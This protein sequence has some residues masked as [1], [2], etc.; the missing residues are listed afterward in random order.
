MVFVYQKLRPIPFIGICIAPLISSTLTTP[1][2][3]PLQ[4]STQ[5]IDTRTSTKWSN[6]DRNDSLPLP[7]SPQSSYFWSAT[8]WGPCN[9][10]CGG[11][12]QVQLTYIS[13]YY[14]L[15]NDV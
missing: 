12:F 2:S 11:G 8:S 5:S 14:Y 1:K 4:I 15:Q 3:S 7:S 10:S 9:S 13:M 6:R